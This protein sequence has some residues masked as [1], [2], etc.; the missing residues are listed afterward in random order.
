MLKIIG[1]IVLVL[2]VGA[3]VYYFGFYKRGKINDRDGDFIP[4]E[5]E[6]AADKVK[7]AAKEVKRRGKNVKKELKDVVEAAKELG[8]QV[9][10]VGKAVKGKK[11]QGRKAKK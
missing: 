6:D 8:N 5:I 2:V 9:G 7:A 4:D 10:D 1:L 3:A 11:R